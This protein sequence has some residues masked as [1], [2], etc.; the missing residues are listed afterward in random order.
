[1]S[2][3]VWIIIYSVPLLLTVLSVTLIMRNQRLDLRR[4]SAWLAM[5][6]TALSAMGGLW[7]L[8]I[9]DQLMKRSSMDYGYEGNCLL[10]AFIGGISA[11]VWVRRTRSIPSFGTL[12]ASAWIG[13]FWMLVCATI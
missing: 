1:M 9:R 8:I 7:G 10:L 6:F 11:L 5:V 13:I 2:T 3:W 12:T 4:A